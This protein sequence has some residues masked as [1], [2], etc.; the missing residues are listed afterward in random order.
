MCGRNP[1][2][3]AAELGRTTSRM[4]VEFYDS[5][6]HPVSWPDELERAWL[7]RLYGRLD[8][9]LL[10]HPANSDSDDGS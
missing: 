7:V 5:F 3:A 8:L 4:V 9:G 2:L 10:Q 6:L 1:K